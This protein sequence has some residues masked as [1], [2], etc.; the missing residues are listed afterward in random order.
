MVTIGSWHFGNILEKRH[1]ITNKAAIALQCK[2]NCKPIAALLF[3][4]VILIVVLFEDFL[5]RQA[6]GNNRLLTFIFGTFCTTGWK[7]YTFSCIARI[8][9]D[10]DS[11]NVIKCFRKDQHSWYAPLKR[12]NII[13]NIGEIS[14]NMPMYC[15]SHPWF[16]LWRVLREQNR[17]N[18]SKINS[19]VL[20]VENHHSLKMYVLFFINLFWFGQ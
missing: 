18:L 16:R 3:I 10:N 4:P 14:T 2:L 8:S 13:R 20:G 7:I 9:A 5:H 1:G 11:A 6:C 19:Q 17:F 15:Y 12:G